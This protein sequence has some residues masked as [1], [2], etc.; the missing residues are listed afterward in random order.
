MTFR[1][2]ERGMRKKKQEALL[3]IPAYNEE[4]N[5]LPLL[6]KL[7]EEKVTEYADILVINDAS[8]DRTK[9]FVQSAGVERIDNLYHLGYGSSLKVGY[10]YALEKGYLYVIQMDGDGQHDVCNVKPI[11]EALCRE[12]NGKCPDIVLG[13]RFLQQNQGFSMKN[14]AIGLFRWAI[15][16]GTGKTITDPTSGLQGLC[17]RTFVYYATSGYFDDSSPDAN[18]IMQML[19]LGYEV[20]EIPAL[21]HKREHGK[22]M[23]SGLR[24]FIYMNRMLFSML[25]VWIRS[26]LLRKRSR[27]ALGEKKKDSR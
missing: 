2:K 22:S 8:V 14:M 13:S 12:V 27:K 26:R 3:L 16:V 4:L 20:T 18:M 23:H 25:A 5:I 11:Y 1:E 7:K 9:E 24:P 21:M 19:L 15:R 6:E 10:N 17:R